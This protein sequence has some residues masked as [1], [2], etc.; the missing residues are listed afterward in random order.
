MLLMRILP[1][2]GVLAEHELV[3]AVRRHGACRCRGGTCA[4]LRPG[5]FPVRQVPPRDRGLE[6]AMIAP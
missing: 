5:R 4:E 3:A 6:S 1:R 2:E